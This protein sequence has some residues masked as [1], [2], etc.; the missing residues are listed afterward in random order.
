MA[1]FWLVWAAFSGYA[2]FLAPPDSP[3]TLQLII[4][5]STG[6]WTGINPAIISLFNLMGV[7]PAI[8]A[9]VMLFDGKPQKFKPGWFCGASFGVGAF[10]IL[11][12]LALRQPNPNTNPASSKLLKILD[13]RWFALLLTAGAGTLLFYGLSQ[14]NWADFVQQWQTKRFIHVMSLDFLM[15]STLFPV[16][17]KDDLAR[18]GGASWLW[19]LCFVPLV[20][21]LAYL[22]LRPT[23]DLVAVKP[24][25]AIGSN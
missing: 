9:A 1:I 5:L 7:W 10:A 20:G 18:R 17:A 11:P 4:D 3:S 13:S 15:L 25:T 16:L 8:Y 2:F 14:G 12:Y 24:N 23:L 21:A 19:S 22:C 6:K